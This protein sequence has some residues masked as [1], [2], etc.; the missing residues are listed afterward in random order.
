MDIKR[1]IRSKLKE[2]ILLCLFILSGLGIATILYKSFFLNAE[3]LQFDLTK[4]GAKGLVAL[5]HST[6]ELIALSSFLLLFLS[7]TLCFT[8]YYFLKRQNKILRAISII[9]KS[10]NR[11]RFFTEA[12]PSIGIIRFDLI[13]AKLLD[14]NR[15]ALNLFGKPR[16]D[17]IN[18]S[19]FKLIPESEQS[20]L[21]NILAQLQAGKPSEEFNVKIKDNLDRE[22]FIS[23]HI[24][25]LKNPD[26]EPEAVAVVL[27]V[28]DKVKAEQERIEKERLAGALE[29]AGAT[30]HELNQPLQ[31]ISGIS[32]MILQ[33]LKKDDPIYQKIEKIYNEVD[34]MTKIAN[35]ISSIS[36]YKVKRY[37]GKTRIIDIDKAA[38]TTNKSTKLTRL[39]GT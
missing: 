7:C 38:S 31:V 23:L 30:A 2:I 29:M 18:K 33:K 10:Q 27:D 34:R 22:R 6:R 5:L 32:W 25:N 13:E 11:Y 28:T 12:P 19:L 16:A 21:R 20:K 8:I 17:M 36:T 3:I 35:K 4:K 37:V 15:A 1:Q 24:T 26:M 9:K 14:A 39:N